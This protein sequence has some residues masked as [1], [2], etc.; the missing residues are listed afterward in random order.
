VIAASEAV[1]FAKTGGLADVAG[2][3][4]QALAAQGHDVR[5]ILPYYGCIKSSSIPVTDTKLTISVPISSKWESARILESKLKAGNTVYLIDR[6][7][8]YNRPEL[9]GTA[10]S[11][12][13]DNAER[14]CFFSQAI[15]AVVKR[16]GLET[17]IIHCHDWQ[18]GLVCPLIKVVEKSTPLFQKTGVVFTVH[19]LAYQG[20]FWHYDMHLTG[21]PWSVFTPE[22]I[23]FYGKIN[24]LKAGIVYADAITT[25][26]KKYSEEIQ[27]K[28]F[29]YGMDGLLAQRRKDLYGILNGADYTQWNPESDPFI[30]Q[31]YRRD[32]W[33]G[34]KRCK[35]DLM[36][37][38]GIET[39]AETAVIGMVGRMADQKGYD[40]IASAIDNLMGMGVVLIIL[41]KGEERYHRLLR[42]LSRVYP[43]RLGV[44]I[45]FDNAISH[46]IEAG[47]DFFLMPSRY[48]PCGLNQIYGLRYGTIPIVRAT[49]GLDDTVT[50]YDTHTGV[51]NGFKFDRY[52]KESLLGKIRQAMALYERPPHWDKIRQNAMACD[53][54]W[55]RSAREYEKV[56][57]NVL[58]RKQLQNPEFKLQNSSQR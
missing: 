29:G 8:Y 3:L 23:E 46:K 32:D 39:A 43:E 9:Y 4:P 42:R 55:D 49:G 7:S 56:Y 1:P 51:G 30:I 21:L 37:S 57:R 41:G 35:A 25:V 11:D 19:N 14:F 13:P 6:E 5:L 28:E 52:S 17:D 15:V 26:S 48:E 58:A 45:A 22:G 12:Y 20:L 38:Y 47:S 24:L 16:M 2:A 33:E 36:R 27:T 31:N 40:L 10:E 34:K 50:E 54:S 18:T 44:K 53:F